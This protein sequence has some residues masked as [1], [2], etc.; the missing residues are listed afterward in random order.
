[1]N[2]PPTIA[3]V[4]NALPLYTYHSIFILRGKRYN[5]SIVTFTKINFGST[6]LVH[7]ICKNHTR[8]GTREAL[9]GSCWAMAQSS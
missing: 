9:G 5:A 7:Q 6:S 1:M 3:Y 4:N 8:T 2:A